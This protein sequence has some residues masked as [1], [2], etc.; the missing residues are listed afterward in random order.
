MSDTKQNHLKFRTEFIKYCK[1]NGHNFIFEETAVPSSDK[2]MTDFEPEHITVRR[3][4]TGGMYIRC[5][6]RFGQPRS[7]NPSKEMDFLKHLEKFK[8]DII[9]KLEG[10]DKSDFEAKVEWR[11]KDK[12]GEDILPTIDSSRYV[13]DVF[14]EGKREYYFQWLIHNAKLFKQVFGDYYTEFDKGEA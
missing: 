11:Y 3:S 12:S 2:V 10:D 1:S 6:I 8:K 9:K 13:Q 14:D 4:T 7:K 5:Q